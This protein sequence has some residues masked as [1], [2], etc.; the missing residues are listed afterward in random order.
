MVI[1]G[2]VYE[3]VLTTRS[4]VL[5]DSGFQI[6]TSMDL[7]AK[8]ETTGFCYPERS[9]F[10]MDFH[11]R[12]PSLRPAS[13]Q[14]T[15]LCTGQNGLSCTSLIQIN[16]GFQATDR[17]RDYIAHMYTYIYN[18]ILTYAYISAINP[19]INR[20]SP[21]PFSKISSLPLAFCIQ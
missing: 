12:F 21:I 17:Y 4:L 16:S 3:T 7:R 9:G 8:R 6:S 18:Y 1:S 13:L 15:S 11:L 14:C 10:P 2:M 19:A 20:S 5:V